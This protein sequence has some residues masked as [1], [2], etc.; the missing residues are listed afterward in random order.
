AETGGE[1][2]TAFY[3]A[4][5]E[6]KCL[7]PIWGAGDMP[8][9]YLNRIDGFLI[10]KDSLACGLA[11]PTGRPVLTPDVMEEPL[12]KPWTHLARE[13]D[14]RGCWSF[15]IRTR[16]DRPVGTFAM[17]FRRPHE[18]SAYDVEL[19]DL[20]TQS[21]GVIIASYNDAQERARAEKAL[22]EAERRRLAQ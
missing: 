17:Y 22:R 21:A 2:R 6:G 1:V 9:S 15:P 16:E 7:H 13:F 4:D 8:E 20:I 18:A 5:K 11:I 3:I 12:W 10:G 19:A 14:F